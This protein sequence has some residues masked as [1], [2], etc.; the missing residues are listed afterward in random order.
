MLPGKRSGDEEQSRR[1]LD[2]ADE[3]FGRAPGDEVPEWAYRLDRR[4]LDVMAG[5]CLTQ[6]HHPGLAEPLLLDAIATYDATHSR[7]VA[8]YRTWLAETYAQRGDV[9]AACAQTMAVLDTVEAVSSARVDDRVVVLWCA[10]RRYADVHAVRD[11]E[12]RTRELL[13][14]A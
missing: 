9:E 8:L 5:R 3:A 4:E 1:A 2:A 7:E 10:L 12:E 14:T 11:V 13:R 6:L